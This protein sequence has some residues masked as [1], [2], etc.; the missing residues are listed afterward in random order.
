[1]SFAQG[2]PT[3]PLVLQGSN[4][5]L[6]GS[7]TAGNAFTVQQLSAG[8]VASFVTSTG[9]TGLIV[10]PSGLV[11]IGKTNPAYAL[12]VTGD[13]NF[14]G[15]F[16]QNGTPYIGS[17][18]TGTSTLFFV[19]NVGINTTSVANPLTVGGTVVATTFSGSGAS[20]TSLPMG[21]ASGTLAIA[22]GGTGL[23][24]FTSGGLLYASSTSALASSAAYT[25]GQVLYGGGA[26]TAPGSSSGLFWDSGNSRLGIG[27][28][29]PYSYCHIYSAN[30]GNPLTSGTNS[31]PSTILR[32]HCSTCGL[33]FGYLN[34][35]GAWIQNRQVTASFGT[36]FPIN[37]NPNGGGVAIGTP[38]SATSYTLQVAG[39]VGASSSFTRITG[40]TATAFNA[41][42]TGLASTDYNYILAGANDTANRLVVFVNGSARTADGGVSNV[43]IRND[44][45]SLILGNASYPTLIYGNVGIGTANPGAVLTVVGGSAT[46]VVHIH[47]SSSGG[48]DYGATY[49]MVNLTRGADTVKA[50]VAFIRAGYS[51]WQMGY[52]QNTNAIGMF[53]G[54]FSGTQG[55]PTM[56]WSGGNVGIGTASPSQPLDVNG[57]V[58]VRGNLYNS[59]GTQGYV[60]MN[61]GTGTIPG[62]LAFYK[63]D[64]TRV[65][66][67]GWQYDTNTLVLSSENGFTGYVVSGN[68]GVGV[69]PS[70]KLDVNG[71]INAATSY[72]I[73]SVNMT[74]KMIGS[75][76][77]TNSTSYNYTNFNAGFNNAY[78]FTYTRVNQ[79]STIEVIAFVQC[80]H[81]V[82][83]N[84][85]LSYFQVTPRIV[86]Q[87]PGGSQQITMA[88]V[89]WA[90]VD[91]TFFEITNMKEIYFTLTDN[92]SFLTTG[93]TMTVYVQ[94]SGQN[95]TGTFS[96]FGLNLWSESTVITINEYF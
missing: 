67:I 86:L 76:V 10:N 12:D 4:V 68:L 20:L 56:T 70:Y 94:V 52:I 43:T 48:P 38:L 5:F 42:G 25:A 16:R 33:D 75:L 77:N 87:N 73:K 49:G 64:N 65:G 30:S 60:Q 74:R 18:W 7:S 31:D 57:A 26:G 40:S 83:A 80:S 14:T 28:A 91:N 9:A 37:L 36:T 2:A 95:T 24:S 53:P 72:Y 44:L 39:S 66:Y 1:M 69:S 88:P 82:G 35:G 23:T 92:G 17:Q 29:T 59:D 96:R 47:D 13:L 78:N 50:H 27:T 11:G 55:T 51:V 90:R 3:Q 41:P 81:A 6:Y 15:T 79:G 84:S 19:G 46:P 63:A 8:N 54:N 71:N 89:S 45:G 21:Q 61:T 34:A 32:V 85:S 93:Q 22:N 62:Y 58:R